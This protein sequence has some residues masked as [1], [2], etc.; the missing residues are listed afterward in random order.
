MAIN[1]KVLDLS[2]HNSGPRGGAIDFA[3]I[4][5]AGIRGVILKASQGTAMV[6]AQYAGRCQAARAAGLLVGA[7]HFATADDVDAQVAH[8][9]DVARPDAATLMALDH[10]PNNGNQL[11]LDGCRAF[12][13]GASGQLGRKLVLYSG[14]LIKEQLTSDADG[15]FGGHRLWLA[16]YNDNPRWPAAWA[17]PWLH[18]FSGDGVN[19]HGIVMPGVDARQASALDMNSF[20]GSDDE[21][22]AQWAS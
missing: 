19:N 13:E 9:L 22:A 10:E 5:G 15:F 20:A 12:L 17:A 18:Q 11:D 6:D 16:H 14:N 21:L 7:Y 3:A 4:A 1:L 8:F 2:H